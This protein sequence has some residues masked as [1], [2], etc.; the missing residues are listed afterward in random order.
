VL[1]GA[2]GA[3]RIV[4]WHISHTWLIYLLTAVSLA[5]FAYG[6]YRR[7]RLWWSLGQSTPPL[8][9]P[10][11]RLRKVWNQ[12]ICHERFF[13][14]GVA[15]WMHAAIMWSVLLLLLGTTVVMVH[16]DLGIPIMQGWFYLIFQKLALNFAG[17]F[18]A[19]A[20]AVA[21]ARRYVFRVARV[22]PNRPGVAADASDA[23]SLLFLLLLVSQGFALQAI[24]LAAN[25]D[26]YA[27][28][29]PFGHILSL[30][31]AG[32][33][34]SALV[35]SYQ[36]VWW[37]H[38]VTALGWIAWLPYGKMLHVLTGPI[39]VYAGNPAALP[40]VPQALDFDNIEHLGVSRISHFTWKDL[41]DL[42]A[43]TAC[44]RCQ[45][46]CPAYAWGAPLSPRN[47]I[48][49]LRDHLRTHGP[50]LAAGRVDAAPKLVGETIADAALWACTSCGAC[51]EECPVHIEPLPKI[52][53]MRRHLAMEE[54]RLPQTLQDALKS[55]EDRAHPYKG[56]NGDR[57]EWSKGLDLPLAGDTENYD[58]LYWVGCTASFDAR[59]QKVARSLI[60]LLRLANVSVAVL[61]DAEPC[62]GDPAR[63]MGHEF[64]YDQLAR[65]NVELLQS[66][67]PKRIV[68][69][70]PHCLNALGNE[71]R[72]FGGD[73]DVV[74]HTQL[75][76]EL[77]E[78]GELKITAADL[79]KVTYHD[80]CYLGRYA[81]QYGA[82][83]RLIDAA[84]AP[85]VEMA[86]SR[87][88]SFCCGGGGG[89]AWMADTAPGRK[90][91]NEI[92]ARE[93]GATGAAT[94]AV[95]CPFCMRMLEDGVKA[96]GDAGL[97]VRDV[98]E[99][100]LES[101][102]HAAAQPISA[103]R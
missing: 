77:V 37:F 89:H 54:V 40:R 86:R 5:V 30:V 3:T 62:C 35:L 96:A 7:S 88:K 90:C 25:P 48:L 87:S 76:D 72:Q 24:R 59:S 91:I 57:T 8:D 73:F 31:I 66:V 93:A 26:P 2:Q 20:C 4:Y 44:G 99:V 41:L 39:N 50:A 23:L 43:C 11:V 34:E 94:L 56:A 47:L 21:L 74:H 6:L 45:E 81:N 61:G 17:M 60:E 83:R 27:L 51:V 32:A 38:L 49:D 84:G 68:T 103:S 18:L 55:L 10:W 14:D 58:V 36:I 95:S 65:S 100:L 16:A 85:R 71:Y 9:Q 67:K 53:H 98:A 97:A 82:P 78:R 102:A 69:A 52:T 42:D 70:C 19:L 75:L 28:W 92:R 29:S 46:A 101:A 33:P 12:V 15:G 80:P 22:Q 1:N 13:R 79:A 64:L 63:R